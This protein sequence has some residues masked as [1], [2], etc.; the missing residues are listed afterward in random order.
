MLD[1]GVDTL[2]DRLSDIVTG[3]ADCIVD[4]VRCGLLGLRLY[5]RMM[6]AYSQVTL[7]FSQALHLGLSSLHYDRDDV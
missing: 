3:D 5:S 1:P 6:P 4:S 7:C 2:K